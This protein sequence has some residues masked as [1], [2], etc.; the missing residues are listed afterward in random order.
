V[1]GVRLAILSNYWHVP[2]LVG[3]NRYALS[4]LRALQQE[5]AAEWELCGEHEQGL[6]P[7]LRGGLQGTAHR[8]PAGG[9]ALASQMAFLALARRRRPA[10]W[11]VLTDEPVPLLAK[12]PVVVTCHGLPRWLRFRHLIAD[13]KVPG[14]YWAYQEHGDSLA[15]RKN[16]L[17]QWLTWKAGLARAAAVI[18]VSDYVRWELVEKF[19]VAARKIHVIHEAADPVFHQERGS[20]EVQAVLARHGLP[21]RYVLGVASF[22]RTKN[23]EGLVRL[24]VALARRGAEARM[25]LVGPAGARRRYEQLAASQGLEPGRSIW[26]LENVSDADLACLYRGAELFVNLAWEESFALPVAEAMAAGAPVL[27]TRLTAVPEVLAGGGETVDPADPDAV[28]GRVLEILGDPTLRDGL[29]E[30]A[31]RRGK[32]LSWQTAASQTWQTYQ[33]VLAGRGSVVGSC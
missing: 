26:F 17:R 2:R 13:G 4:L 19:G 20:A 14:D 11:H 1:T 8:M 16:T 21:R 3:Y 29:R 7:E 12:G 33:A 5:V 31:R 27:A 9:K 24:A 30:R 15:F 25:V 18:A 6:H 28:A 32:E 23:T 10:L 22:A